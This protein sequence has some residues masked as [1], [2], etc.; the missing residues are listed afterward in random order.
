VAKQ[1]MIESNLRL[2]VSV[3]RKKQGHGLVMEDL[4]QE[5]TTGLIRAVE[6]FDYRK[7]YKFS[8]YGTLWIKQSIDRGLHNTG[9]TI[10]LPV[11]INQFLRKLYK[12]TEHMTTQLNRDPNMYELSEV[13]GVSEDYILEMIVAKEAFTSL[14]APMG[15]ENNSKTLS[16]IL[17]S[18]EDTAA[19]VMKE[20][21]RQEILRILD[22]AMDGMPPYCKDIFFRRNIYGESASSIARSYGVN[23]DRVRNILSRASSRI[24]EFEHSFNEILAD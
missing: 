6:K 12:V 9:R 1:K 23:L 24:V 20:A 18:S 14:D 5:G 8:T 15:P 10:R 17:P 2:V 3:A 4:V 7:G 19:P 21:E 11:H 16:S 13:M 22:E